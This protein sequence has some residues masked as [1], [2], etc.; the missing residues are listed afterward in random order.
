MKA[1]IVGAMDVAGVHADGDQAVAVIA[2]R[3]GL[4]VFDLAVDDGG[5]DD[6]AIIETVKLEDDEGI[7]GLSRRCCGTIADGQDLCRA[8]AGKV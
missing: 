3:S 7:S 5:G 4:G 1:V 2:D 6:E 8:K